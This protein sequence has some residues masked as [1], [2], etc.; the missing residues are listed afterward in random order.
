MYRREH[1]NRT[2]L[3][4]LQDIVAEHLG[5]QRGERGSKAKRL[6]HKEYKSVMK[7]K[8]EYQEKLRVLKQA[9]NNEREE[10]KKQKATRP[11]YAKLEQVNKD[12]KRQL[13][14]KEISLEELKD[15][16]DEKVKTIDYQNKKLIS[17]EQKERD[18]SL[19]VKGE[20]TKERVTISKGILKKEERY[21]YNNSSVES[22]VVKSKGKEKELNRKVEQ[23][24]KSN[25]I[26]KEKANQYDRFKIF[27]K[28]YFK[29]SDFSKVKDLIKQKIPKVKNKINNRH[30]SLDTGYE[31]LIIN[32]IK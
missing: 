8:E 21:I 30:K 12:L 17:F 2:K 23:L 7:E 32:L 14:F 29:T 5:M 25:S 31:R 6:G 13:E 26:L 15:L 19:T 20:I 11:E 3:I 27:A 4:K 9:I 22:Y 16:I 10:L 24:E 28:A 18:S 1:M